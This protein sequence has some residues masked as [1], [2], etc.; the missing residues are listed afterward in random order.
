MQAVRYK[1]PRQPFVLDM[2]PIPEPNAGEV[3]IEVR[4]AALCHTELHFADGTLDL[5]VMPIT[6]GHEAAGTI[7]EVGSGVS[8]GRIGERVVSY[9]YVGCGIC[10]WCADGNQQICA[11]LKAEYGFISDG[12]L[13][14]FIAVPAVNAVFLPENITFEKAAPIGCGVTTA[15]HAISLSNVKPGE[16]AAV[17][18]VNGVGFGLVQVLKHRGLHVVA[19][20]RS[21]SRREKALALGADAAIDSTDAMTVAQAVRALTGGEGADVL[22]ECVG[23]RETMDACVG[24]AGALGRRGRLVLVG[25]TAGDEH[26]FRCE[27]RL[28]RTT[29]A[30]PAHFGCSIHTAALPFWCHQHDRENTTMS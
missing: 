11:N 10:R 9:Y 23:R 2:V 15:V 25:Y 1:G 20:S 8:R 12:G 4:A 6:M 17:Y 16:W 19:I 5:G 18:G 7:V 27:A 26:A 13:A 22:F 24:F 14:Q 30:S 21:A 28:V 3:L 29:M